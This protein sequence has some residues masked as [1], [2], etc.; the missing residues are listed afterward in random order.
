MRIIEDGFACFNT[1]TRVPYRILI[2][3][4]SPQEIQQKQNKFQ[5][6]AS[7]DAD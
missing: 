3:T 7:T 6:D 1:K 5:G 2:E 4:I